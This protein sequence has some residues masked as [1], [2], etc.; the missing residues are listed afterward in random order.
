MNGIEMHFALM[1]QEQVSPRYNVSKAVH[2]LNVQLRG[3]MSTQDGILVQYCADQSAPMCGMDKQGHKCQQWPAAL[4]A[5]L[6]CHPHGLHAT[7][8]QKSVTYVLFRQL[9]QFAEQPQCSWSVRQA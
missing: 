9:L 2:D 3:H 7:K 6:A 1:H 8:P 5:C 4:S